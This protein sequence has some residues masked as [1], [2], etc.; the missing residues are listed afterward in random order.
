MRIL[1]INTSDIG[2]GAEK[3]A[4]DLFRQANANNYQSILAVGKK[5]TEEPGIIEIRNNQ[6]RNSWARFWRINQK[7]YSDKGQHKTSRTAGWIANIAEPRRWLN[8]NLGFED[9]DFPGIHHLFEEISFTPDI[10]HLHN[11]HGNYFDFRIVS[12][13]SKRFKV[14]LTLHDEWVYTGHCAYS[15]DCLRWKI[16]CGKCQYLK[17]YP[18]LKKD[19]TARNIAFKGQV[20]SQSSFYVSASSQ[21]LIER[22]RNSVLRSAIIDSKVIHYGIDLEVFKPGNK[23]DA[24]R[25]LELPCD[26]IIVLFIANK[27]KTNRYKDFSTIEQAINEVANVNHD[28]LI[29]CVSIGESG[30]EKR[31]GNL[32]FK[33]F[34]Y[35]PNPSVIAKFYQAA[36]FYLHAAKVEAF[37]LVIAEAMACGLPVIA[38]S[39]GGI[40]EVVNH[41]ETGYLVPQG[42]CKLMAQRINELIYQDELRMKMS[43]SSCTKAAKMYDRK[44]QF[45]EYISW[46]REAL[47]LS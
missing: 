45:N 1:H 24:R 46:Y 19:K 33:Y 15:F 36:D 12:E 47:K 29:Y 35:Q 31:V 14:F 9:F 13:L 43:A 8:W 5:C 21:W 26:A 38:T 17:S 25:E 44:R 11:L 2:G 40:P 22:A 28:R 23:Q 3:I 6:Y 27:G 16:G 20:Y 34:A 32:V 42:N 30:N 10:I 37:G 39:V 7:N 41:A 4:L 18:A